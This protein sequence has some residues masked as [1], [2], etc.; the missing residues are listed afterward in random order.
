M[1][2]AGLVP[3]GLSAEEE[4]LLRCACPM[5]NAATLAPAAALANESIDVERLEWLAAQ[6]HLAPVLLARLNR[7]APEAVPDALR[8]RAHEQLRQSLA[9]SGAL[10]R[11]LALLNDAGIRA[12]AFKGP[13]LS[14][15]VYGNPA[16]RPIGDLDLLMAPE[17]VWSAADALRAAGFRARHDY[18]PRQR[19]AYLRSE[20]EYN[21]AREDGAMVELHWELLP[22]RFSPLLD[23]ES[24]RRRSA[25]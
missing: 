25:P 15:I 22:G 2:L 20:D 6:H 7:I 4:L 11:V 9:L 13:V 16:Q 12:L 8:R 5:D 18:T 19:A 17:E 24:L 23:V 1:T 10:I 3:A 14:Q 21:L